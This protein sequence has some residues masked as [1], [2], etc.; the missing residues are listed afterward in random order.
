MIAAAASL[1]SPDR[2]AG[3]GAALAAA[4]APFFIVDPNGELLYAN[5]AY[6]RLAASPDVP[7]Y[8]LDEIVAE[9]IAHGG[10]PTREIALADPAPSRW[11]VEHFAIVD[12]NGAVTGIAGSFHDIADLYA[13][14]HALSVTQE[15]LDDLTRLVSDWIWE[16]DTALRL[17]FVSPRVS[18][19][20]G[21]QP[22]ELIGRSLLELGRFVA[23]SGYD[24]EPLDAQR[25]APFRDLAFTI[26]H[27]D[28]SQRLFHVSGLPIF[29]PLTG[30]FLGFRGTALDVSEQQATASRAAQSQ[31]QLTQALESISEGFALF[32]ASDHLVLSNHKF[33]TSFPSITDD[34]VPGMSFEGF[35]RAGLAAGD[36]DLPPEKRQDWLADR[37]RLRAEPR[38]SFEIKLRNERWIKV[39]DH[40][41]ADGSTV[42]IRTDITDLKHREEALFAAKEAAE[43]ASRSKSEFLA[44]ISHEL[45]TPLNAI[46]GFS[47][48]MREEIFGPLGSPQYRE[49][50]GDVLDSAHHLLEVINDILDIAKAEA[51]KLELIEDDVEIAQVTQSAMRLIQERAQRGGVTIRTNLPP[52]LPLL[53]ADER[54]LKQVLLNLLTNAVKFTP[55]GGTIDVDGGVVEDGAFVMTVRDTGIGIA[56]ENIATALAP[57]GQVDAKLNRKYEGTGLGLPLSNAMIHLHQGKLTIE[58]EVGKGTTV[59]L[60]LPAARV[61]AA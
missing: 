23:A 24:G 15:R 48:I 8:Q 7:L 32:D 9:I 41:T 54:K 6:L 12:D 27:R 42:G 22:V 43:I 34:I 5:P 1:A 58:S 11:R 13:A 47:E 29:D 30:V 39:S 19:V 46:I 2:D 28:G 55:P 56:A 25:R 35:L 10:R 61:R 53:Y 52:E 36:I 59:T 26:A 51:G 33:R 16:T 3:G 37:L 57:F 60:R 14:R 38:A 4:T 18:E 45:R 50:I 49:Y 31:N 21:L 20:L 17:T 44:N 40:R